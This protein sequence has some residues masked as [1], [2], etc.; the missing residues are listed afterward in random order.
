[1]KHFGHKQHSNSSAS[2]LL[3]IFIS[4][5]FLL[6]K[7]GIFWVWDLG[8][9]DLGDKSRQRRNFSPPSLPQFP[10]SSEEASLHG[11]SLSN[12]GCNTAVVGAVIIPPFT[13]GAIVLHT[14]HSFMDGKDL[15]GIFW[16]RIFLFCQL[17][18]G[19]TL[20]NYFPFWVFEVL[21]S[22]SVML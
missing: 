7:S 19:L 11:D 1:M 4:A 16:F 13:H 20:I 22:L 6:Q 14:L 3:G 10:S 17:R 18:S 15:L 5:D 21:T 8:G 2:D 9:I 12:I